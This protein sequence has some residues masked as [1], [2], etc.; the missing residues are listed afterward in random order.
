MIIPIADSID[1]LGGKKHAI[2]SRGRLR[3]YVDIMVADQG[4]LVPLDH[5]LMAYLKKFEPPNND[6]TIIQTLMALGYLDDLSEDNIS[7]YSKNDVAKYLQKRVQEIKRT[8]H[9]TINM[10]SS[11]E[12]PTIQEITSIPF[13]QNKEPYEIVPLTND[14]ILSKQIQT[15]I[16]K[17]QPSIQD[18]VNIDKLITARYW[19]LKDFKDVLSKTE[20]NVGAE[21]EFI[22]RLNAVWDIPEQEFLSYG[23]NTQQTT[24]LRSRLRSIYW[25]LTNNEPDWPEWLLHLEDLR[26]DVPIRDISRLSI[27]Q[28]EDQK[29]EQF[30]KNFD[31]TQIQHI[32]QFNRF[33]RDDDTDRGSGG[34]QP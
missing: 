12:L 28:T 10:M 22:K 18:Y 30:D 25:A 27:E 31:P 21:N 11:I 3:D 17:Q 19:R 8:H 7:G 5:A 13:K 2:Q 9:N 1:L 32:P 29:R 4:G 6:M 26:D 23:L 24:N 20:R 14:I 34:F 16:E 33:S 15:L